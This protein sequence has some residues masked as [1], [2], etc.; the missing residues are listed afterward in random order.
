MR[1]LCFV[2]ALLFAINGKATAQQ[3]RLGPIPGGAAAMTESR[4]ATPPPPLRA[5]VRRPAPRP[6]EELHDDPTRVTSQLLTRLPLA[7]IERVLR[8]NGPLRVVEAAIG[9][10][11]LGYQLHEPQSALPLAQIAVHAIKFSGA[12]WLDRRQFEISPE[13]RR[14]GFAITFKKRQ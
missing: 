6:A 4:A 5:A 13:V 8:T 9:A 14:G 3:L 12:E 2:A 1:A 10:S 7:R 11:V